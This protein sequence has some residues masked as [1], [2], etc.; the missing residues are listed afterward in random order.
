M[1]TQLLI[2][3]L[4]R[5]RNKC[6]YTDQDINEAFG[7]SSPNVVALSKNVKAE[8]P[9]EG[10]FR[11]YI[12]MLGALMGAKVRTAY[13]SPFSSSE[14]FQSEEGETE[15]INTLWNYIGICQKK[16]LEYDS[17]NTDQLR[18]IKVIM[19]DI[20]ACTDNLGAISKETSHPFFNSTLVDY[21]RS[22]NK[23]MVA[24]W[25][26]AII[27]AT[28]NNKLFIAR[29]ALQAVECIKDAER[30]SRS[31]PDSSRTYLEPIAAA[32]LAFYQSYVF[33]MYGNYNMNNSKIGL[34][35]Q[36]FRAGSRYINKDVRVDF[37]PT[38]ANA[39]TFMKRAITTSKEQAED[40]NRKVYYEVVKDGDPELPKPLPLQIL[41]PTK[42]LLISMFF[43]QDDPFGGDPFE[44]DPFSDMPTGKPGDPSNGPP[45][46]GPSGGIPTGVP[47][48]SQD[49]TFDDPW[50]STHV[51]PPVNTPQAP[52]GGNPYS[53]PTLN[54]GPTIDPF[55]VW[56]IVNSLKQQCND[57]L[58]RLQGKQ[59]IANE[60]NVL[61]NQLKQAEQSD[62]AI[63]T[64]IDQFKAGTSNMNQKQIETNVQHAMTFYSNVDAKISKLEMM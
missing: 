62:Q 54:Q 29:Q 16:I 45:P 42:S 12:P 33:F 9:D 64:M 23:Y 51:P 13:T 15:V 38:L 19:E 41:V 35:V 10:S 21:M 44:D 20:L 30:Y 32:T 60:V 4:P 8:T 26:V 28:K 1:S 63:K 27:K 7:G 61:L 59:N 43:E 24:I 6:N 18:E 34:G 57:R 55:P 5:S 17:S 58:K 47:P 3:P 39:I 52:A 50:A 37:S 48:P 14:T 36:C 40:E 53:A 11:E 2:V 46:S 56:D 31:L 25:Q 49:S 22:Y